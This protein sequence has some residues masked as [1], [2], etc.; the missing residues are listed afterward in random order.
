MS[1]L[2]AVQGVF[3]EGYWLQI[4]GAGFL[5]GLLLYYWVWYWVWFWTEGIYYLMEEV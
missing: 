4:A 5:H 1:I 2:E 3:I